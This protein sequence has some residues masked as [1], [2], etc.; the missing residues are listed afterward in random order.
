MEDTLTVSAWNPYP[1]NLTGVP[2]EAEPIA[3][4]TSRNDN[5]KMTDFSWISSGRINPSPYFSSLIDNGNQ[6]FIGGFDDTSIRHLI[7]LA[8]DVSTTHVCLEKT[9]WLSDARVLK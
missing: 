6:V 3:G 5:L 2:P 1:C 4:T 7:S 9:T 8:D